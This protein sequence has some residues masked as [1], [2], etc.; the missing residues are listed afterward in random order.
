MAVFLLYFIIIFWLWS[1]G[2]STI[3]IVLVLRSV[4]H[5]RH[6]CAGVFALRAAISS[7]RDFVSAHEQS[8]RQLSWVIGVKKP[9][10]GL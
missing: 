3:S 4:S 10:A 7:Q 1:T 8:V 9:L 6:R 5:P 2:H